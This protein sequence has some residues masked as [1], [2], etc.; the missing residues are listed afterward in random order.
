MPSGVKPVPQIAV[1]ASGAI[2]ANGISFACVILPRRE[3]EPPKS[4]SEVQMK[5]VEASTCSNS[6]V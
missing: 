4:C 6:Y 5:C 2:A 1:S 3:S